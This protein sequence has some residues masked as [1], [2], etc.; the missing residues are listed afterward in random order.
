MESSFYSYGALT[1]ICTLMI[2]NDLRRRVFAKEEI[3]YRIKYKAKS[4]KIFFLL[5][6]TIP[7]VIIVAALML[8]YDL[9]TRLLVIFMG[10]EMSVLWA[11]MELGDGLITKNYIGK[12]W[13]TRVDKAEYYQLMSFKKENYLVIKK[14]DAKRADMIQISIEDQEKI[15]ET[16]KMLKIAK[17]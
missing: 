14:T 11:I 15:I 7:A 10:L 2:L 3:L 17:K 8:S 16:M 4:K 9:P 6:L 1:L 5:G 13:F 12:V